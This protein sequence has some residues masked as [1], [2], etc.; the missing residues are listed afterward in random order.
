MEP[1]KT[2]EDFEHLFQ[3]TVLHVSLSPWSLE[4]FMVVAMYLT[5]TLYFS[6]Y[7]L[8]INMRPVSKDFL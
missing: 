6:F 8:W 2:P 1:L 7:F 4:E 3:Y 5:F